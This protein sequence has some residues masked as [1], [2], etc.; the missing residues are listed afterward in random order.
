MGDV[1]VVDNQRY[2]HGRRAY[3]GVRKLLGAYAERAD[4]DGLQRMLE[5]EL[6]LGEDDAY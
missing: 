6:G 1:L 5:A 4:V 3:R 2:L